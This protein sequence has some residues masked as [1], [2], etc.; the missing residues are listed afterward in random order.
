MLEDIVQPKSDLAAL[1]DVGWWT[2]IKIENHHGG[3][4]NIFGQRQRWM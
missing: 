1:D 4:G 2:G 3:L